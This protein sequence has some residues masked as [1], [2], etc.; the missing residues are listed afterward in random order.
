MPTEKHENWKPNGDGTVRRWDAT[1][2]EW[3]VRWE[4]LD[5]R[6]ARLPLGESTGARALLALR[7]L[8]AL[9]HDPDVA[10]DDPMAHSQRVSA[11]LCE[12]VAVLE[13]AG[14]AS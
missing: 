9:A 12:A 14:I 5:E 11:V 4:T 8:V 6:K 2:E 7:D 1:T 10:D 3:V 13:A